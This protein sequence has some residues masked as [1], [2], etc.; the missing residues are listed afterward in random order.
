MPTKILSLAAL[1]HRL[2]SWSSE[3]Q[4]MTDAWSSACQAM[5]AKGIVV[6]VAPASCRIACVTAS[7]GNH[8]GHR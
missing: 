7:L 2:V 5:Y 8:L 4:K 3:Q 1:M 6:L